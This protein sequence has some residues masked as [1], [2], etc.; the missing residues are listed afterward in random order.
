M[1]DVGRRTIVLFEPHQLRRR[2]FLL[3]VEDVANVGATPAVNR[4]IV[5]PDYDDIPVHTS[6][7][8][9][10]LELSPVGVLIFVDEDELEPITI[11]R[12][13]LLVLAKDF[14]GQDQQIVEAD[15]IGGLERG[16][17]LLV[18]LC[19]SARDGIHRQRLVLGGSNERVLGVGNQTGDHL[20]TPLLLRDS[21]SLHKALDDTER[22]VLVIDREARGSSD[23]VSCCPQDSR[24]DGVKRSAPHSL[25]LLAKQS[26]DALPHLTG[27]L[28]GES[29]RQDARG[30]DS[31][32]L[33]QPRDARCKYSR[34]T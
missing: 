20:G 24:A 17:E 7:Q 11:F 4:L 19:G 34:L 1:Q 21:L 16:L 26:C 13:R 5:V 22:V 14:H 31:V 28:V 3:E 30:I 25:R 2:E 27:R 29:D 33:D 18:H 9:D 23:V 32:M 15:R 6:Q 8:L 10:E 12:E